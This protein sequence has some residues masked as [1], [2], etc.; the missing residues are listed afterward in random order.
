[1]STLEIFTAIR[2]AV[3]AIPL[4]AES[5]P[6]GE[7]LFEAVELAGNKNLP[8]QLQELLVVK[9]RACLIVPVAVRRTV[10]DESGALSVLGRRFAELAIIY[11]DQAYFKPTQVVT[12][13]GDKNLGLFGIDE[14][15]EAA[16]TGKELSPFGGVVLLDSEPVLFTEREA[17]NAPGRQAWWI[18]AFVPTG[19]IATDVS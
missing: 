15:L 6:T 9:K 17:A 16:L 19:L 11:S 2:D 4:D 14:K 10:A 18:K 7:T 8:A 1:M 5:D 13:G 12:F 3:R